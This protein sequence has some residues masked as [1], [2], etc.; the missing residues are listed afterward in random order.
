MHISGIG[1]AYPKRKVDPWI[2]L[3]PS[4]NMSK[5]S[6]G[7]YLGCSSIRLS[8][9]DCIEERASR[10]ALNAAREAIEIS[11][12]CLS[13][14]DLVISNNISSDYLDWQ[15]SAFI[16]EQLGL[17]CPTFD[18]YAGCN[19]SGISLQTAVA[20]LEAD[21][22]ISHIL[23][24]LAE[25]LGG[26]TFPQFIADG[27]CS[28]I[29]SRGCGS[30]EIIATKNVN[31]TMP[32]LGLLPFGGVVKPFTPDTE[33]NGTWQ[34]NVEISIEDYRTKLKPIFVQLTCAP[35]VALCEERGVAI[36]DIAQFFIVHQQ[37]GFNEKVLEHL[38][39]DTCK[40]PLE[41]IDDMGHISGFDVMITLKRAIE[42]QKIVKDDLIALI[43]LGMGEYHT[44]LLRV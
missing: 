17:H 22:S 8:D 4:T 29:V 11:G 43:I 24:A 35:I 2:E 31:E 39:V 5:D 40:S 6:L 25:R 20:I 3:A 30:L 13:D 37:R 9:P 44:F 21:E 34:D 33:F 32:R 19:S 16:A 10:L 1:I 38:G 7:E 27:A 12:L 41:Y 15:Q 23:I 28:W 18:I 36:K 14:I 26:G 42:D